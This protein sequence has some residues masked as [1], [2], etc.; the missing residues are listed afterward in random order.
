MNK[1]YVV[2][3][4]PSNERVIFMK[5]IIALLLSVTMLLG[6]CVPAFASEKCNCGVLP[7]IYVGPLGNTDIYENADTED[8]RTLFR[9][10]TKTI[11]GIV[12]KVLPSLMTLALPGGYDRRI[13][14]REQSRES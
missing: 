14:C 13:H 12:A 9:P 4:L 1:K 8:E 3:Y 11:I 7:T 6:I 10:D 2:Q 5:K